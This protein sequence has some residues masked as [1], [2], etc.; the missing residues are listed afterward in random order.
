[1]F[2]I[3]SGQMLAEECESLSPA[4][5]GLLQ[6]EA[7]AVVIQEVVAGAIVAVKLVGLAM[8]LEL[9]F[10]LVHVGPRRV[11][12]VVAEQAH[13]WRG[14]LRGHV[15]RRNRSLGRDRGGIV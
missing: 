11:H 2:A 6:A 9:G 7:G 3:S 4:V 5:L 14:D 12:V 13:Q 8:T 1:M 15:D 10:G